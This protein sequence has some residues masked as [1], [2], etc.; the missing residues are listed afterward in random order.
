MKGRTAKWGISALAHRQAGRPVKRARSRARGVRSDPRARAL[1]RDRKVH[2]QLREG[3][4]SGRIAYLR[5]RR[6]GDGAEGVLEDR[7]GRRAL[8]RSISSFRAAGSRVRRAEQAPRRSLL[9]RLLIPALIA[10]GAVAVLVAWKPWQ[11]RDDADAARTEAAPT[12]APATNAPAPVPP[13]V[14]REG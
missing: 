10:G 12:E 8:R 2:R 11:R 3:A 1:L 7:K 6:R 9:R 5:A 13:A 4:A 14:K